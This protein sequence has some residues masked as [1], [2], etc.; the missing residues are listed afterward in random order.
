[1][2]NP[3]KSRE[4]GDPVISPASATADKYEPASAV[5]QACKHY[6]LCREFRS[7]ARCGVQEAIFRQPPV[8]AQAGEQAG[9]V[10][11][12][13]VAKRARLPH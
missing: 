12:P 1:M 11:F 8:G 7:V 4:L 2:T 13:Q 5:C 10:L 6:I 3:A 9:Y